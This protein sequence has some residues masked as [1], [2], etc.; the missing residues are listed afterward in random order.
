[1]KEFFDETE[2]EVYLIECLRVDVIE[3]MKAIK[4][5]F[6]WNMIL[7]VGFILLLVFK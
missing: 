3:K 7:T 4:I 2:R 5:M 1:M 6:A